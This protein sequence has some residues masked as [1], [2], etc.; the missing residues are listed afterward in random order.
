MKQLIFRIK[1]P[2]FNI[3]RSMF[4]IKQLMFEVHERMD[5][6]WLCFGSFYADINCYYLRNLPH[7]FI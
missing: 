7:C 6:L 1:R 5:T 2:T 4:E 3:K